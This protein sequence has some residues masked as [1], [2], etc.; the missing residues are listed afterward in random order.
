MEALDPA[1]IAR[2]DGELAFNQF[3]AFNDGHFGVFRF[4]GGPGADGGPWEMHPDTDE[5]LHVLAGT[6]TVEMYDPDG[7]QTVPLTPGQ[8]VVVRR[9]HWH[10]HIDAHD[11]VEM[12]HTPGQSLHSNDPAREPT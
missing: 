11:L 5:L 3:A 9:G 1:D 10:R 4:S 8:L 7:N 12:Y 6:V 2:Q